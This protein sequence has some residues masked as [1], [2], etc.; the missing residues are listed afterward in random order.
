MFYLWIILKK[1]ALPHVLAIIAIALL[2]V[3]GYL[4]RGPLG[5][6]NIVEEVSEEILKDQFHI[7]VEFS[8][9]PKYPLPS[10]VNKDD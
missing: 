7:D 2:V 5:D 10:I 9:R 6:N 1:L 8:P 3:I 4:S